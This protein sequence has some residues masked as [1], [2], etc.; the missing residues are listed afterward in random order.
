[1]SS[2]VFLG[3]SMGY[4]DSL[5]DGLIGYLCKACNTHE[6]LQGK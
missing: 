6:R 4:I 2:R 3:P 5:F 1:M